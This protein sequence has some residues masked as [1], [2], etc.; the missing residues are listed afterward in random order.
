MNTTTR[1]LGSSTTMRR[2]EYLCPSCGQTQELLRPTADRDLPVSC[3]ECGAPAERMLSAFLP[4]GPTP[5][6]TP[7]GGTPPPPPTSYTPPLK[8]R[9]EPRG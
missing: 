7:P 2:Y 3:P 5:V 9:R 6:F 4:A 1:T 8:R